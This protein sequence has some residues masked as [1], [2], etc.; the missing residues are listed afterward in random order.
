MIDFI[1]IFILIMGINYCFTMKILKEQA[2]AFSR[3]T[4]PSVFVVS[5]TNL[6]SLLTGC[7]IIRISD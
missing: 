1:N 4:L 2:H 7:F 6:P 3:Y 5:V